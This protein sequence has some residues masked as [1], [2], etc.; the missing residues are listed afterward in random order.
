MLPSFLPIPMQRTRSSIAG[1]AGTIKSGRFNGPPAS[2][3]RS[4]AQLSLR[5]VECALS[6]SG[7][8]ANADAKCHTFRCGGQHRANSGNNGE[9]NPFAENV[10]PLLDDFFSV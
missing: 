10:S 8:Q 3:D 7:I 9:K 4:S 2:F 6:E 1:R 5:F